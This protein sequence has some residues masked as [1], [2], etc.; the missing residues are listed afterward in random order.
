MTNGKMF[1][2][3]VIREMQIPI[4]MRQQYKPIRMVKFIR[5]AEHSTCWLRC[6]ETE[7]LTYS[8]WKQI[9]ITTLENSLA[10]S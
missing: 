10:I 2:I 9:S 8:W 6:V 7:T 5:M 3:Q 1:N 4:P